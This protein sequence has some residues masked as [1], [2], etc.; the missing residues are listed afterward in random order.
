MVPASDD[1]QQWVWRYCIT[2][3]TPTAQ[4]FSLVWGKTS[5]QFFYFTF[6]HQ[7]LRI[8]QKVEEI[9]LSD[10]LAKVLKDYCLFSDAACKG[11]HHRPIFYQL[12]TNGLFFSKILLTWFCRSR[13]IIRHVFFLFSIWQRLTEL[14]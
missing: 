1:V 6:S 8:S 11:I 14:Q 5:D 12:A 10:V 3:L 2:Q 13:K 7:F 4:V 9:H